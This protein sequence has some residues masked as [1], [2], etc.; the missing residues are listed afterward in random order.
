MKEIFTYS[1]MKNFVIV[2]GFEKKMKEE[3][4]DN[5]NFVTV[6]GFEPGPTSYQRKFATI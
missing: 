6:L 5:K 1:M 2:L 4:F 3:I